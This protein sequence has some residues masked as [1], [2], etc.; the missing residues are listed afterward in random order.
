MYILLNNSLSRQIF[1]AFVGENT[2]LLCHSCLCF[3]SWSV[4]HLW[5]SGVTWTLNH[6]LNLHTSLFSTYRNSLDYA[7]LGLC[8]FLML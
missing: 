6:Y 7:T 4:V 2:I 8:L 5:S 1:T 3:W